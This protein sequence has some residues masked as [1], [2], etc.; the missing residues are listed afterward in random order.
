[1]INN[2]PVPAQKLLQKQ[3]NCDETAIYLTQRVKSNIIDAV[4]NITFEG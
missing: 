4:V 3:K 2:L 1:M